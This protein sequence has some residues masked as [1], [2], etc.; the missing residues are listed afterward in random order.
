MPFVLRFSTT[1]P[2]CLAALLRSVDGGFDDVRDVT[3]AKLPPENPGRF[4]PRI[5]SGSAL[6]WRRHGLPATPPASGV[7]TGLDCS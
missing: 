5:T 1:R 2:R 3:Q 7:E 4:K 6:R